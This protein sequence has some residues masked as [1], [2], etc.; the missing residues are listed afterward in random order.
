MDVQLL[1]PG[2]EVEPYVGTSLRVQPANF[3]D[4]ATSARVAGAVATFSV[5]PK[6]RKSAT[7]EVGIQT[8]VLVRSAVG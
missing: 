1:A 3:A 4:D 8:S 5:N 7:A 6:W 2:I